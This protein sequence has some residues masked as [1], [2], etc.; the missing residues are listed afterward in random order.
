MQKIFSVACL[1]LLC[2]C[3]GMAQFIVKTDPATG[4]KGLLET[5]TNKTV[6]P[7]EYD[8]VKVE[9]R[10]VVVKKDRL[11]GVLP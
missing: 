11:S 6:V 3:P 5:A 2:F 1:M 8:E 9:G 10:V 4:K 7:L